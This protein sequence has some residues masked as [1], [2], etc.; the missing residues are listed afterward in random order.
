[1][2]HVYTCMSKYTRINLYYRIP[3][4]KRPGRLKKVKG[5][6]TRD[7]YKLISQQLCS[8]QLQDALYDPREWC[9]SLP[10]GVIHLHTMTD[11]IS[12]SV[13]DNCAQ[14]T[15][16]RSPKWRTIWWTWRSIWRTSNRNLVCPHV[17]I[18]GAA[19]FNATFILY[20]LWL[21]KFT[22]LRVHDTF[23]AEM[24]ATISSLPNLLRP[25]GRNDFACN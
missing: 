17:R 14:T 18:T 2:V 12:Q 16:T 7:T 1:M 15:H 13:T 20:N 4:D 19:K 22:R 9:V 21:I 5:A 3:S 11:P 6:L 25:L 8:C 24:D 23:F 10:K